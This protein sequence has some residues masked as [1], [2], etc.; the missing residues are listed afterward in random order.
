MAGPPNSIRAA[1]ALASRSAPASEGRSI[2]TSRTPSSDAA[3]TMR[4]R[5]ADA[6]GDEALPGLGERRHDAGE[7]DGVELVEAMAVERE[8]AGEHGGDL[9][10]RSHWRA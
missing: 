5:H 6:L 9:V 7:G 4:G 2:R 10:R 1:S 3:S 8:E